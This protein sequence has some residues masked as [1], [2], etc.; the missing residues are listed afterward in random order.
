MEIGY[1]NSLSRNK[2][3]VRGFIYG[4]P[5]FVYVDEAL[6]VLG[7]AM[8][9]EVADGYIPYS[10]S[11]YHLLEADKI[12]DVSYDAELDE[13][14]IRLRDSDCGCDLQYVVAANDLHDLILHGVGRAAVR[15]EL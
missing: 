15:E 8:S 7:E 10:A 2:S 6:V 4:E 11:L 12:G 3:E 9:D 5:A 1:F 13:V 14:V